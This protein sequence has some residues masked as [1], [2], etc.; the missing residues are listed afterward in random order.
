M[1]AGPAHLSSSKRS[2]FGRLIRCSLDAVK[3]AQGASYE[4]LA[5]FIDIEKRWYSK[6]DALVRRVLATDTAI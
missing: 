3:E 5:A 1:G 6:N 4:A 2:N